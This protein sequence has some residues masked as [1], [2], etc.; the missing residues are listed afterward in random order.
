MWDVEKRRVCVYIWEY[1]WMLTMWHAGCQ[2]FVLVAEEQ[3][4]HAEA[5][6]CACMPVYLSF[7]VYV[8]VHVC[9]IA[10]EPYKR[11]DIL[12]K[13]P[14]IESILYFTRHN[15]QHVCNYIYNNIYGTHN[16]RC[17]GNTYVSL[18]KSP[19]KETIF[20]KRDPSLN[21]S[22]ISFT[23]TFMVH[24][25]TDVAATHCNTFFSHTASHCNFIYGCRCGLWHRC[26]WHHLYLVVHL[27]MQTIST[28]F[29]C[30][31]RA[32]LTWLNVLQCV[33]VC[34]SALQCVAVRCSVSQH[35]AARYSMLLFVAVCCSV[36]QRVAVRCSVSQHV[37]ARYSMLLFVAVCCSV[38]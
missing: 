11:D 8:L 35:V 14:I 37:A 9:F 6:L 7:R 34:C 20:C 38:L 36:L 30:T 3:R 28:Q 12:Q 33:A 21:R 31:G 1:V 16:Y 18:Q 23:T 15:W 5:F 25:I 27:C 22:Y 2:H 13:R 4:M 10:K 26:L 29:V 17:S 19:I 32:V 24:T